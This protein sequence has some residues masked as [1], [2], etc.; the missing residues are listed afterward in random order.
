M[1]SGEGPLEGSIETRGGE[2]DPW[3]MVIQIKT[4]KGLGMVMAG[5]YVGRIM[6][7]PGSI[8]VRNK[9]KGILLEIKIKIK[10]RETLFIQRI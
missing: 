9:S 10:Q 5:F 6:G 4:Q 7:Q 1:G 8:G 3:D 2:G